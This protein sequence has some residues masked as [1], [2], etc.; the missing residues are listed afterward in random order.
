MP[1]GEKGRLIA[2]LA[3]FQKVRHAASYALTHPGRSLLFD[4]ESHRHLVK[5]DADARVAYNTALSALRSYRAYPSQRI[6][7]SPSPKIERIKLARI[8]IVE[9][10]AIIAEHLASTLLR[11]GYEVTGIAESSEE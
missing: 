5:A 10:E 1:D 6:I 8:L 7:E 3:E 2:E 4:S 9:D 11:L